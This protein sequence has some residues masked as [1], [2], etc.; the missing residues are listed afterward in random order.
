MRA[1]AALV[2][3]VALAVTGCAGRVRIPGD[4]TG[5][6][7]SEQ[8]TPTTSPSTP[9][10]SPTSLSTM[11]PSTTNPSTSGAATA[12]D[13]WS[14]PDRPRTPLPDVRPP[15]VVAPPPGRGPERYLAQSVTWGPCDPAERAAPTATCATVAAPLDGADPDGAALSL[16]L[17][18]VPAT[19]EPRLGTLFVNPGGPGEGGRGLAWRFKRDGLEQY[20]VVGWDP[21]GTG[22]STPVVCSSDAELDAFLA[23]DQTP[24]DPAERQ[25]Y[26]EA[27]RAFGDACLRGSGPLLAHISTAD[28]VADLDLLRHLVGDE[29]LN[30]LGYSYGTDLG[31]RYADAHPDRVG[32]LVLDSAVNPRPEERAVT[33]AMGFDRALTAFADWCVARRCEL[34]TDRGSVTRAVTGLLAGLDAHPL[35]V[36][37]RLVTQ[38]LGVTG[39]VFPLY[40]TDASF[41]T[42][43]RAVARARA[44]DG[45]LLLRLADAYNGRAEG[46]YA[47]RGT[48]F[49]AIRCLDQGDGGIAAA[50]REATEDAAKAPLLGPFMGADLICPTWP[51]APRPRPTPVRAAGTGP[52]LVVGTTGDSATPYEFAVAMAHQLA[53]GRL[54]TRVGE[55]HAAYGQ[56]NGC[57]DDAVVAYLLGADPPAEQ[58]CG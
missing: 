11:S 51:V 23:L 31:S 19:R 6:P 58:R 2:L 7:V 49:F 53:G 45:E 33:Q 20:D 57:V 25:A 30:Y 29:K 40:G 21:R 38:S 52:I 55:G 22:R 43:A 35:V 9:S 36:R 37:E 28:T 15:G 13:D 14:S 27:S 54:L 46:H 18:R 10:P 17:T 39:V 34:G 3:A 32:R 56:G 42:L 41:P 47:P 1:Y 4:P 12:G 8:A 24:D 48:A 26:L 50:E 16:A 5:A 44:G